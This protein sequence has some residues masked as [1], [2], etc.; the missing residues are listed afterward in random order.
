LRIRML[1]AF[2]GGVLVALFW[3]L[4]PGELIGWL[5]D[6]SARGEPPDKPEPE[7]PSESD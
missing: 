4:V 5:R 7:D 6:W 1:I 3:G 2:L